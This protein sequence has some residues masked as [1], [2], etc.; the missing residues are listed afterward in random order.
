MEG[1]LVSASILLLAEYI[2]GDIRKYLH[3]MS[4]LK[5]DVSQLF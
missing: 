4:H 1:H 2:W 3:H 5:T